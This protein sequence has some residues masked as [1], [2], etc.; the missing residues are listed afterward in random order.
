MSADRLAHTVGTVPF[1][2]GTTRLVHHDDDGRQHVLDDDG[3]L[4][5]GV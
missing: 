5:F 1:L 3:Q 4:I 2:D